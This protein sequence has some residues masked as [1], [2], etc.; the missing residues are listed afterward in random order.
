MKPLYTHTVAIDIESI[1]NFFSDA[2]SVRQAL[3]QHE[4]ALASLHNAITHQA[5]LDTANGNTIQLP[6][7]MLRESLSMKRDES[8]ETLLADTATLE[9]RYICARFLTMQQTHPRMGESSEVL[10][11]KKITREQLL[12]NYKEICEKYPSI[13]HPE[14]YAER[15]MDALDAHLKKKIGEIVTPASISPSG[16]RKTTG[17]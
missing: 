7:V 10:E 17:K 13:K 6:S 4:N 8:K 5:Y 3:K 14:D 9:A 12:A 11:K 2:E 15:C 16:N 1:I